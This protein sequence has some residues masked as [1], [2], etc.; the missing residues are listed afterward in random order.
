MSTP[1]K[2]SDV[3]APDLIGN[4]AGETIDD[5]KLNLFVKLNSDPGLNGTIF[6]TKEGNKMILKNKKTK[7]EENILNKIWSSKIKVT[8]G[9]AEKYPKPSGSKYLINEIAYAQLPLPD[10]LTV[11]ESSVKKLKEAKYIVPDYFP[12]NL[13]DLFI[14]PTFYPAPTKSPLLSP[15]SKKT[16][17]PDVVTGLPK[18]K[19][20]PYVVSTDAEQNN[21]VVL[22]EKLKVFEEVEEKQDVNEESERYNEANEEYNTLVGSD[23]NAIYS[24]SDSGTISVSLDTTRLEELV[25]SRRG[26][27]V[28][29]QEDRRNEALLIHKK[30]NEKRLAMER[31]LS[32]PPDPLT[33]G[34][35]TVKDTPNDDV[36]SAE[37]PKTVAPSFGVSTP[38][39][40]EKKRYH[41]E[42]LLYYFGDDQRPEWD[43]ELETNILARSK[44]SRAKSEMVL[45]NYG[46]II[47][48]SEVKSDTAEEFNELCQLQF[49]VLRN[50]ARGTRTKSALVPIKTL[51]D[52]GNRING[53]N[54]Q[55]ENTSQ[56]EIPTEEIPL[57]SFPDTGVQ[58]QIELNKARDDVVKAYRERPF[59]I[60][61]KPLEDSRIPQPRPMKNLKNPTKSNLFN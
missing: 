7:N 53:I 9:F 58:V 37:N 23:L 11:S 41:P 51:I 21:N 4:K 54:Q 45:K 31:A 27:P 24:S 43:L 40:V 12:D 44:N 17:D 61:G 2:K 34:I 16:P 29:T 1:L 48:I 5:K 13:K 8:E 52:L 6:L 22:N 47:F 60:F 30:E 18:D 15:S 50:L 20:T 55:I 49:C 56:T 26:V 33:G 38:A 28:P 59:G 36:P 10:D 46:S 19:E 39:A 25:D 35:V 32:G 57:S 14:S 3:S 42:S